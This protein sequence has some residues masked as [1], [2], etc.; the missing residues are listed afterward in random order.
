MDRQNHEGYADPTAYEALCNLARGDKLK[1]PVVFV[2]S[3]YAGAPALNIERARRYCRFAVSQKVTPVAPH[4]LFPQFLD[5]EDKAERAL[6]LE[7]G[8]SLLA[9]CDEVWV[10]G[11]PCSAGMKAEIF[12]AEQW[13]MFVKY[14]S[15][16]CTP[17]KGAHNV[18]D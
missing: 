6:G 4:L 9:R 12:L 11:E 15:T 14:F 7:M 13:G 3:A 2:C 17:R 18:R 16:H 1:G 10:F 8:R 5:E